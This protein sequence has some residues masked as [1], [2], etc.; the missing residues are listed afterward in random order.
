MSV[1]EELIKAV[2]YKSAIESITDCVRSYVKKAGANGI[3]LGLSGG[4][5]SSVV[6][7]LAREAVGEKSVTA[8]I[9]PEKEVPKE[10][11]EDAI[12]IAEMLGINYYVI[13]ITGLVEETLKLFGSSYATADK[14]AKGNVKARQ[15]MVLLYYYAN[16][17]N[18]LVAATSDRSEFLLG[19]F[20][21]WGDA[22]GDIYPILS[23]YKTQVR[24][25][26]RHLGLP[27]K[28]LNKP[29]SPQL[30]PGQTAEAELG[31]SYSVLDQILYLLID[32][33]EPIDSVCR[34]LKLQE[35]LVK[36]VWN[37]VVENEHKRN[38]LKRC[39]V[40]ALPSELEGVATPK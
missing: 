38:P 1:L 5:D 36:S 13:N 27:E 17:H 10:T 12:S 7:T 20:T 33:Q 30:W 15:R 2:D 4:I 35:E 24:E 14:K 8:L 39:V 11:V 18:M 22:S 28:I 23:L 9:M 32:K 26:G 29:S 34:K 3:V 19:Y 16:T 37:R 6:A 25:L 31:L 21:K 40:G